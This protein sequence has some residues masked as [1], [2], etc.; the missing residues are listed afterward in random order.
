MANKMLIDTSHP[1]ETRVVTV[2]GQKVEEFDFESAN[3]KQLRGN[4]YLAKVTR[5]E[6]SLQAAFVEYGGNRHGFL[7]FSEIHPDYY[8]IPVADR[9]ALLEA[10]VEAQREEEREEERRRKRRRRSAPR[11]HQT[12]ETVS[13][14]EVI[15]ISEDGA[16][17]EEAPSQEAFPQEAA[18]ALDGDAQSNAPAEQGEVEASDAAVIE[19]APEPVE[20]QASEPANEGE[21]SNAETEA[22]ESDAAKADDADEEHD[23][24]DHGGE[25]HDDEDE[26][27]ED[28]DEEEGED[29]EGEDDHEETV[30]QLGGDALEDIPQRPR[31]PRKQYKIQE[32]IKRRQ[33]LLVQVVKEERGNKGAALTTYLSLAGRYSVLMPNTGRGGGISRKITNTADRKRLKEIAQELEVPEGMGIILR[34]AGASRTK[35]EIKRDYEYL[36]RLWESVRELTLNSA[37]PALVYEEGSLIKRA[38][39]DLYNK[40]IDDILVSGEDGY[41]EAKDFMRML[42][43]SHAK[44]VQPYRDPQ[45][46]F[47]KYGVEAQLDAMFSSH[48]TLKSGG[49]LVINPT[50]AL[51]SIDVNSGR[52]TREHNIEDTALRTNLEAAEEIARQLRLRDLAGL[53]VIDFIDMEEKRNNRAVEKKLSECLKN[54]RARIQVGRISPFGLLEMSRQRI[55]TGVLE[56][57]SV[58][59]AHC[60]GT[61]FVRSTPS[62]ALHVLRSIE[63]TLIKNAGYNLVVRT[64]MEAAFYILNQKRIHLRDLETR[65]GVAI[66][67]VADESLTGTTTYIIDRGEP[68]LR[69]EHKSA[70]TGIQIDAIVPVD[71][72]DEAD[73]EI[74]I[75]TDEEETEV[76][77]EAGA[78]EEQGEES[79]GNGRRRRRRRRRRGRDREG[80]AGE[81][82]EAQEGDAAEMSDEDEEEGEDAEAVV[83]SAEAPEAGDAEAEERQARRRRRGRRGGRGRGR[84][85]AAELGG[86][87]LA[88]DEDFPAQR[89][90]A[91]VMAA[92]EPASAAAPEA[93]QESIIAMPSVPEPVAENVAEVSEPALPEPEPVAVVLTPPDPDRPKRA[94]W[95]SKAKSVLSGS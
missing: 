55:R 52:S 65:F 89:E 67:I 6:P 17:S 34:T 8:Q 1:E 92:E 56:S 83:A 66:S 46:L 40:D 72:P 47:A 48:V 58:P 50:E 33:V 25:D 2:R 94:G 7:A 57:S 49:Y 31:L 42:M 5:V 95:W 29:H 71:E 73:V 26:E 23:E 41:R 22:A 24:D 90:V 37:A 74:D 45:P 15:A 59:C 82:R 28:E 20:A 54:D 21:P 77:E 91:A 13:S 75:D 39:R 9:Q 85:E 4:I 80:F 86:V 64:R 88:N 10:E 69:L 53:I 61:G 14:A 68:A 79:E 43:P 44:I 3:R 87:E 76:V 32:V 84:E 12:D 27:D 38:I 11:R 19:A 35:P 70:A 16:S 36:M 62:V 93:T 78:R 18:P 51:V 60:A 63:E 30:E 81:T